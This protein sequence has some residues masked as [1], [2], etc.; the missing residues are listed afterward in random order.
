MTQRRIRELEHRARSLRRQLAT[1]YACDHDRTIGR[2]EA[3]L[4]HTEHEIARLQAQ[5]RR[6]HR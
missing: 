3:Q 2:L 1:A 4:E 5:Q 6:S